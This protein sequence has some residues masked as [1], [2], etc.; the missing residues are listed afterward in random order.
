[1]IRSFND[2]DLLTCISVCKSSNTH[3]FFFCWYDIITLQ[4]K[5]YICASR[6]TSHSKLFNISQH[7]ETRRPFCFAEFVRVMK[8]IENKSNYSSSTSA[9]LFL[10]KITDLAKLLFRI[11]RTVRLK[12]KIELAV[13]KNFSWQ[14]VKILIIGCQF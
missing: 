1:M 10:K 6:E 7:H 12:K 8:R 14:F 5:F 9:F 2:H 13:T 4:S 3:N 11:F